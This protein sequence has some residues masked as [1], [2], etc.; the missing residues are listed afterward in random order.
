MLFTIKYLVIIQQ[1][2]KYKIYGGGEENNQTL[3]YNRFLEA[4]NSTG[5]LLITGKEK[6]C[7]F[8]ESL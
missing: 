4:M 7:W 2:K 5:R 6:G 3:L 1:G 8:Q